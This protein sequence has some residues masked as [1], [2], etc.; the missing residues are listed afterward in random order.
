MPFFWTQQH[1]LTLS[2]SGHAQRWDQVKIDG[3]LDAR[4]ATVAY[5]LGGRKLAV[6]TVGRD[7]DGLAAE[8]EF[9]QML[10]SG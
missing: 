1:D 8:H 9:E 4:D 2:Y 6:L 10:A 5:W 7:R 3:S